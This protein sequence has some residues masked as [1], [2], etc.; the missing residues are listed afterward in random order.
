M[1]ASDI[2]T[3]SPRCCSP[4][5]SV[6]DVARTMRDNDCGAVP[7]IENGRIVGIVTDRDLTVRALAE[8][9]GADTKVSDVITADPHCCRADDDIRDVE[10]IMADNQIRRVPVVD[11]EGCCVGIV[12]QADLAR[13]AADGKRL[14]DEEVAIVVE[15]ISKPRGRHD[16][17]NEQSRSDQRL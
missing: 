14:G 2:M 15:Q 16:Q 5:D 3:P 1:N 8:G 17:R 11:A 7:I 6:L 12:S 13:A 9:K 10:K 4:S